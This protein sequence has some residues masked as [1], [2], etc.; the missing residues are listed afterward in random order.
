MRSKLVIGVEMH[1]NA[2]S[3]TAFI[4]SILF[5]TK[6]TCTTKY[7]TILLNGNIYAWLHI[8]R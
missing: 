1:L 4:H 5:I 3:V 6:K 8:D 2:A 7:C